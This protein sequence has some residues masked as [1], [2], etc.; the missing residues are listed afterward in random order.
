MTIRLA[1]HV[2]MLSVLCAACSTVAPT[3]ALPP[4][5]ARLD[6]AATS[7]ADV[8]LSTAFYKAV[9]GFEELCNRF[10]GGGG[11]VWLDLGHGIALHIFG[12]RASPVGDER[13][14]HIAV[15]VPDMSRVTRYLQSKGIAWH[16]APRTHGAASGG[17]A[18]DRSR[19]SNA[20]AV[21]RFECKKPC[22]RPFGQSWAT[23]LA[24]YGRWPP[25]TAALS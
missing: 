15:T 9:F 23:F 8:A 5:T 19:A 6:H 11:V 22:C 1:F 16:T 3:A 17:H 20:A 18:A 10:P 4:A 13:D 25:D 24:I 14:R 21:R 7:V 2:V 12:G